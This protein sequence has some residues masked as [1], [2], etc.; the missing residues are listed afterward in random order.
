MVGT[1]SVVLVPQPHTIVDNITTKIQ[2]GGRMILR[3]LTIRYTAV[4]LAVYLGEP[5]ESK[6]LKS[7]AVFIA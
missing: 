7:A 3:S 2:V 5:F 1:K 4:L 6:D